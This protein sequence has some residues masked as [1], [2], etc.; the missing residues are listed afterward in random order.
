LAETKLKETQESLE[1][2]ISSLELKLEVD[3]RELQ[4]KQ[5]KIT[6]LEA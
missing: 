5:S 4:E 3:S 6:E 2:K 1:T